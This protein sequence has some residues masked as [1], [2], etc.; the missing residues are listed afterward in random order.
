MVDSGA[1][2]N[3]MTKTAAARLGLSYGPSNTRLKMVNSPLTPVCRVTHGVDITLGKWQGKTSFTVA[4]LDIFDII[5]GQEFFQRYHT[6]IDPYLQQ[7]LVMGRK[8]PCMVPLVKMPKKEG[9]AYLSAMQLVK[10]LKKGDP[11]FVATIA[12]LDEGN[13]SKETLPLCIEKVLE[14]NKDVMPK[15]LPR[16]LPPRCEVDHKIELEPGARSPAYPPYRMAPPKLEE[17]RKQ[18]KELLEAGHIRP[19]KAPYGAPI[20]GQAKYFTKVDL[21]KG[22]YQVLRENE[23]FI[24]WEK[25]EFAQPE[26][27]FLG[28]VINQGELRMDEA[29]VRAIKEWKAPTKV[30]KLRSFL[31]LANYYRRF[32]SAYSAKSAPLTELLKKNKPWVWSE[33]CKGTFEDLKAA[34]TEEPVLALPDFSKT[35]EVHTDASDYAIG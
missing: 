17:L 8:G 11:T 10:G 18:L 7:L 31:G 32:I 14:E 29:K 30:T 21:R 1:E 24:K 22:Y 6:M 5:L 26:V 2:A 25:C 19:S 15:E 23:L 3:I 16:H 20:L 35:F 9:Q 34:V 27:H 28:H 13:G 33:E 4:P 12:S